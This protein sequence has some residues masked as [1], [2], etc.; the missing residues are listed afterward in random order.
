MFEAAALS[1]SES[2]CP[3]LD[4]I[5][6]VMIPIAVSEAHKFECRI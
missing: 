4:R 1:N 3:V 5:L 6:R 2:E